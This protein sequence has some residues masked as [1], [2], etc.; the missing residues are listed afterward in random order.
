MISYCLYSI[1]VYTAGTD[2]CEYMSVHES[3]GKAIFEQH[4]C[5]SCHQLFGLGGYLGPELTTVISDPT[6]GALYARAMLHAGGTRMPDFHF[7]EQEIDALIAYLAY[8]DRS[9]TT[10][11]KPVKTGGL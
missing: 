3:E 10:Y 8:V 4:N 1:W 5:E 9:A 11:K 2:T 7:S 6:R